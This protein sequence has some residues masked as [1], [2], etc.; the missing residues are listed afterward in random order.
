LI[1]LAIR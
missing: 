1:C